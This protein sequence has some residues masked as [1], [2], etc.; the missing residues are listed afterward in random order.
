L[1]PHSEDLEIQLSYRSDIV[2]PEQATILLGQYDK[3]LED[4]VFHPDALSTDHA[5]V[6]SNLLSVTP[7]KEAR[8]PTTVS[9]L[10]Q[11]VEV[12]A[13]KIPEKIAFEFAFGDT[14]ESLQKKSWTY[15]QFNE[16][17]N[18]IAHFLQA[19]GAVPGGMVGICFD[20]SPEASMAIL[21]I[22]KT[23]CS[24]LAIDP[25]APISRKQFMLED[26]GTKVLLC[27]ESKISELKDLSGIDV[28]ALDR[29]GLLDGI[30]TV[31]VSLARTIRPDDT[32][33]C[34][35]TSGTTGT[36]K[37]CE[38]THDNAVQAM[39]AFQRLFAGHWDEES[40]WLQFASF[41]F[42][43]SV[44]E[45]YWS[46][47]V[48]ICVTSCPR[49][50]L[51]EDLPGT[52]QKLQITHIDLTPSLAKLVRPDEVPSLC[53]G[54]FITGGE[55]LKQEILDAWGQHGV[56]YN[57]YGPTEVTIGCTM[58][59][60][61][62]ANDKASNIG[63]Q[64]D[65]VGSYVFC[66]GTM[67][68][69]LRGSIGELCV[70]GPLV[71][72]GYLNRAE[73]TKE[74]FQTLPESGDRIYR[75]GD[76]VRILHDGSFQFLGRIDDQVKLRGQRL[77][78][79]EINEVIKQATPEL[80]EVAT[81]VITH[82]KQAKDQLVSF[83]TNL[84]TKGDKKSRNV[85][86][87]VRSSDD[88]RVLLS[89]IKGACRTHLP[90]YMVPTH[91]I[92]MTRFPLSANNK[93]DMKVLKAIYQELSL[94]DIQK[95]SSLGIDLPTDNAL[96]QQVVS[97][98]AKFIGSSDTEIS[99]WSS[100][101]EMGLDSI[102]VIA[103]S[104]R[105]REA[106]FSQ[107]QPSIIM[108]HPTVAGM[109]S[110]LET[111]T[112]SSVSVETLQR[113]AKQY[114]EAFAQ[115]NSHTVIEHIGILDGDVEKI[116]PCTPLQE[117]IIYHYLSSDT[118][119]YCSSFTFELD[120]SVNLEALRTAWDRTQQEVQMLR[121]RF[122]P[123]PDGYAQVI[124]KKDA[125]PWFF[126]T[127]ETEAEIETLRKQRHEQW[128][129]RLDSLRSDLWEVGV[130]SFSTTS[131]MYLNI[132]HGLYDGNSL[133][134]LLESVAGN[135]LSQNKTSQPCPGFLDVLHLGPL[136]KDPGAKEFWREHLADC[137]NR[138]LVENGQD[139]TAILQKAQINATEQV[140]HLRR[141]LNV[142]EQAVLH[143]CWLLTLQ[144]HYSIVPPLGIIAS[145]RTIDVPGIEDVI[146]PLFNTIPSNV[147]LTGLE[148]WSEVAQRCHEYQVSMMPFQYTALRDIV[149][150]LGRNPDER[151]FDSL[152][153]FQRENDDD[154]SLS[155]S[156]W[157]TIGSEA[158]HEYPLAF[159]IVR[160]DKQPLTVTL[161][162]KSNVVSPDDAQQLLSK[163]E[164]I[165]FEFAQ[166][167]NKRLPKMN[168][169]SHAQIVTNGETNGHHESV[170]VSEQT[171][172]ALF[173]WTPQASAIRD[174]IATL[175][176]V[177]PESIGDETSIF[178]V[179]LDSIDAIKISSRLGKAGVKLPVSAIMRHRTVKA[180][181]KQ[182][183]M[184]NGHHKNGTLPLLGQM[185]KSL[186]K[187]LED[188][189]L[190]LP[191]AKRVLPAT[192]IQEAM[193]A[194]IAASGYK[195]YYNH[196]IL[197]LEPEVDIEKLG[198]AWKAVVRAHPILRTSFVE[199]W[200]PKIPVSY[201]QIVH[202][203]NCFDV[204][205]VHLHGVSVE[206][207][208]E[209][210]RSRA[211][212]EF[213]SRPLL[214][215]T[216]AL[217][218]DKRYL[219][220][221]IS[222]AL[223]DGWSINLLHEDV[224]KSYAGEE[225]SRPSSDD[226]LEQ[227]IESSGDQAF[228]F[229]RATL[230]NFTPA[231]FLPMEH[232][233]SDSA[234]VHRAEQSFSVP[235]SKAETF[236]KLHGITL[237]ALLVTCWSLVLATHVQ[238]LD[239]VFGLVLSGR[240]VA[241][242]EH[243]MFPTM[244]TVAMR[245]ILHGTRLELVKYV[246]EALLVMAEHQHF[247]LRRARPD[248]GSK[249]L[250][251]TLFIYQKRPVEESQ[252]GSG[253]ALYKSTGGDARVEYP[254]CAEIEGVGEE[255]VGRVACRGDVM[256]DEDTLVLL[257]QMADI[258]SSIID[259]PAEKT[260]EF[261]DKGV[262][263]CGLPSFEDVPAQGVENGTLRP[264]SSQSKWSPVESKIRNI[265][266]VVSNVPE[267]AIEKSSTIFEL[268]LDSIS[269]I[270]VAALLKKQSIRLAVSDMLRA[271]TIENMAKATNNSQT[272]FS[273]T[274]LS[275][276]LYESL[277]GIDVTTLLQS[278]G[279]NP[280]R[281]QKVFPATAGQSYFLSMHALN[282]EVFYPEFYFMAS[283]KLRRQVLD[284]AWARVIGQTPMLRTAFLPVHGPQLVPYIQVELETVHLPIIWHSNPDHLVSENSKKEFGAVPVALHAC[285]TTKG[286]ALTLQ[287]HH[288]LYDAVS[289]P[290]I[291]SRLAAQCSQD[292]VIQSEP[293]L[294]LS[295]LVAF[296][297]V[298]S[299]VRVRRQFWQKYL[300]QISTHKAAK[301]VDGF[302]SVQQYYRPG[303]VPNM[304][305]VEKVAKRQGLSIQTIFLAI[306][307]RVHLQSFRTAGT[308]DHEGSD[309]RLTVGLYLANRS[310]SIQGLAESV[311]P[312]VNI[313]PLRLDDKFSDT[314]DSLLEAARR[315]QN[316]I[317]EISR[318]EYSGVSLLEIAEWT[319][320]H[321][322]TCV[323]FLRLPENEL[324]SNDTK[325]SLSAIQREEL[326]R[327]SGAE[328]T[329]NATQTETQINGNGTAPPG[330]A[331]NKHSSVPT[332]ATQTTYQVR[333]HSPAFDCDKWSLMQLLTS[334]QP[335]IDVEAAI[336]NGRLDFGLFA[337]ESRLSSDTAE[338]MIGAMRREMSA[339]VTGFEL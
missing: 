4:I 13:L 310:H 129:A 226:I 222:H 255:L 166:D 102:S 270:K 192:P 23:G 205:T 84:S 145:G 64:F 57:G 20:K 137:H 9:L 67:T 280:K 32:S 177:E 338:C 99:S 17:G 274:N 147:Q 162:A 309:R 134:L 90:G 208:I 322:D 142:T 27:N 28:Q 296:Q 252:A 263:V 96:E 79:G 146:G 110:A 312:T 34:L 221:S 265:L 68:P 155:R 7:A 236:C 316:E 156:L 323:N 83:F 35:Y 290:H 111:A 55:A 293:G 105:L 51:F 212:H 29:P 130:I 165:L 42:D 241:D 321:I 56:I 215:I 292:E 282:P 141:F 191:S 223:Y 281:V 266:S 248:T 136:C 332:A 98:L 118:P 173:E 161:A 315:I 304:A 43:V 69:V 78:I 243:V 242:S 202:S 49:D 320:V 250:F 199:V 11:F 95:L 120:S 91:I 201:A 66:P 65:N 58:L 235:L 329:H 328:S 88:D 36:P 178:E 37:G 2:P 25:G 229:W 15:R 93:A 154:E 163:F 150:W 216:I 230:S 213:G 94:E 86:V 264:A 254:V 106:G 261:I 10:H 307:A 183:S 251:D 119:L 286:T 245:V 1:I 232:A 117:G 327:L 40:R 273:I 80:N 85:D 279:I 287:I 233:G 167:S 276:I 149:K 46:W 140:D 89:K 3:L 122:S 171:N 92:P 196:E 324:P 121:A 114:I 300:G 109:A 50:L 48:G 209:T 87:Q 217:E 24:Y 326:S 305:C 299:P 38:I 224:A 306:Y 267:S 336:R 253:S 151:L 5:S 158:Q 184:T 185:E 333:L 8:I 164:Q 295:Q 72:K 176:G 314:N 108:K 258:V 33:Y 128:T 182:L 193:V 190:L 47:S 160:N 285:Q 76:L 44:L 239:V 135:Y 260:I 82:P 277:D 59:P 169:A 227:I 16:C 170:R 14:A 237:Q 22:L 259:Q 100:I 207:I 107:A 194:E 12:N 174:V 218:G 330:A 180:M 115:K 271:G 172:G 19:K 157:S 168:R 52:I 139:S 116:A 71:G 211:R 334:Q 294:D 148:T 311:I 97:V 298:H 127:V 175:A 152:F 291:L 325:F 73:L 133:V 188:E 203:E 143:A 189:G 197:Q 124:L 231:S 81:L 234:V 153:V 62:S 246:Q 319:G 331:E 138:H 181:T 288:A 256:G 18:Q 125:L 283:Q 77:E 112:P 284:S 240:N 257:G 269:A 198:Q 195:H 214:S 210:Q 31:D 204:Q 45:Q 301:R 262:S 244:N 74:R 313:V 60:R 54:V 278:H 238:K 308:A 104:R 75:T 61:M 228:K 6:G 303:L 123:S 30:S 41:H 337:P 249:A 206:T 131:V 186:T 225:C 159:E 247:P 219:V 302:G 21:G 289:L 70:S 187:F 220:L 39:L 272:E 268:G 126:G 335:T 144:Q 339:L 113:N 179:G 275:S 132:F 101:Y 318:V 26:S 103:F 63:P 53:R 297:H 200:D 317:N